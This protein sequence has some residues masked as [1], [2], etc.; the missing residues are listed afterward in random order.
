LYTKNT[1]VY[2]FVTNSVSII[3]KTIF[4]SIFQISI[5]ILLNKN[6]FF[7]TD[8]SLLL[9]YNKNNY[10]IDLQFDTKLLFKS[11]YV[12]F[13]KEFAILRDYL[14]E[15]QAS[16][17]ICESTNYTNISILF[18]FKKDNT[19]R[20]YINYRELNLIIIKNR[21]LLFFIEKI[22]NRL[23]DICYFIKFDFKNIYYRICIQKRDK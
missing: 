10:T 9:E 4:F 22:L 1:S 16:K 7:K 12:L 13:E 19:F 5:E 21:Y 2:I 23:I 6:C 17:R 11:L 20:L 3:V 18:V 15:N 14:L 8:I